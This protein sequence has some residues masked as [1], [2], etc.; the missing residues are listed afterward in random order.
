VPFVVAFNPT[1]EHLFA[2]APDDNLVV[3]LDPY[4]IQWNRASWTTWQG[5]PVFVLD[6]ANAGWI[7]EIGVG[8]G[9]EEGIAVN[10]LTGYVYVTNADSD[11][12][13]ILLDDPTPANIEWIM[14][15]QVG[16]H[17]QGV[18][19]DPTRNLI[20]VG[21]AWSRDLTVIDGS[22]HTIEKTIPLY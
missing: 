6:R 12:V 19:V 4:S 7:A 17:P 10:P 11:T 16:Q 5:R 20:Y 22:D 9:A 21:N 13:S 3:V 15:L 18:D 14:D 8:R 1:T 2:T